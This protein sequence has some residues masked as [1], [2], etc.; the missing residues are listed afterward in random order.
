MSACPS[1]AVSKNDKLALIMEI[2]DLKQTTHILHISLTRV[3]I[4]DKSKGRNWTC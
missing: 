3:C 2:S 1:E 4:K